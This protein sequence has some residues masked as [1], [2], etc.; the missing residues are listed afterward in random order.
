MLM[1]ALPLPA[2]AMMCLAMRCFVKSPFGVGLPVMCGAK[3]T[4]YAHL[5]Q[6]FHHDGIVSQIIMASSLN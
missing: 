4:Q 3:Y 6:S 1:C 5:E 2:L